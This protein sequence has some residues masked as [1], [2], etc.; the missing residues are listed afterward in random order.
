MRRG[1]KLRVYPHSGNDGRA[2]EEEPPIGGFPAAGFALRPAWRS[3]GVPS[4]TGL[5]S[6]IIGA[7]LLPLVLF[8]TGIIHSPS[9]AGLSQASASPAATPTYVSELGP[10]VAIA[11][12]EPT[13]LPRTGGGS[14]T[15]FPW[16]TLAGVSLTLIG[17][18]LVYSALRMPRLAGESR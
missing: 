18:A 7:A 16:M 3:Q 15:R 6:A 5:R 10:A 13:A 8:V 14:P 12:Q 4:V 2:A 9:G 1:A 17:S 11:P